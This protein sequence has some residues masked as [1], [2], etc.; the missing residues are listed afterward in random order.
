MVINFIEIILSL[1]FAEGKNNFFEKISTYEYQSYINILSSIIIFL[2]GF[3]FE[4]LSLSEIFIII[5]N[6]IKNYYQKISEK[7]VN[8]N[9]LNNFNDIL[10]NIINILI[11]VILSNDNDINDLSIFDLYQFFEKMK[12]IKMKIEKIN[13]KRNIDINNVDILNSLDILLLIYELA[14][15]KNNNSELFK[16]FLINVI[17]NLNDEINFIK[18]EDYDGLIKNINALKNILE[19]K[20]LIN[21]SE[22]EYF[23][24]INKIYRIYYNRIQDEN[25]RFLMVKFSFEN[26]KLNYNSIYFLNTIFDIKFN[27]DS[28]DI[29]EF[30][31]SEK[32][33]RYLLFLNQINSEIFNQILLYYFEILFHQ[34]ICIKNLKDEY[35][36]NYIHFSQTIE[37][38]INYMNND[39]NSNLS[40]LKLVYAIAYIKVFI[41]YFSKEYI[42][43]KEELLVDDLNK[44]T[45]LINSQ[46]EKNK[47]IKYTL[48]IYFFKCIYYNNKDLDNINKL[49]TYITTKNNFPFKEDYIS[50]HKKIKKEIFIF[51]NCLIPM[52]NIDIYMQEKTKLKEVDKNLINF[53]FYNTKAFDIFYCLFINQIFSPI[54]NEDINQRE[55]ANLFL[56]NFIK[57]FEQNIINENPNMINKKIIEVFKNLYN[58]KIM[59]KYKIISC[60]QLEILFYAF[61]FVLSISDINDDNNI[62]NFYSL[63]LTSN[64]S[65]IISSSYVPGTTPFNNVYLNSYYALKELMPITNENEYGFYICSCGQYYTLGKCTC[66]AY[67]FNCQNCGLIIGGIGHYLEERE[68]HFRLYLNKDKF[69]ENVFAREEV[70]SNKIPYMFF[71]EYK[72]KYIDKYLEK[73]PKGINKEDISF[74]I[75]RKNFNIRKMSELTFRIMNFILYSHLLCANVIGNLSDDILFNNYTH[76]N[77]NCFQCIEKDWEIIND[78]LKEKGINNIRAFLNI[79]FDDII[80]ILKKAEN[81]DSIDK[82]KIVEEN[83]N[84]YINDLTNDK[85]KLKVKLDEYKKYNEKIKNS[86]PNY[87]DEIIAENYPPIED[88]YPKNKYPFLNYFMKSE[89][90]DINILYNELR[91]I[92]NYQQ[93]YPLINQVIINS[94]EFRLLYNLSNINKLSN[95][96]LKKY[97]YKISR[98]ESQ[99]ISLYFSE[100]NEKEYLI[101]FIKSWNEIKKYC[102]RYLCRPD[103]PILDINK[104]MTLNYFLVDDGQLGGGMYLA[105]AYSN[106]IEWQNKFISLILDN[107][108]QDSVLYCYVEQL[109]EEIYVQDAKDENI[110]KLDENIQEKLNDMIKV[111]SIRNIFDNNGDINY[112]NYK[113]I[114]FNFD[115]IESEL[116]KLILPGLKKFKSSEDPIKFMVYLYE[117]NRSQNSQILLK[118][119][120]KYPSKELNISEKK[121]IYNFLNKYKNNRK[122]VNE[123]LF[124]CQ[125][126]IDYIHKENFNTLTSIANIIGEIPS[127]IELNKEL[128]HFFN[129]NKNLCV[130]KLLN[131]YKYFEFFCWK[132]IKLNINEQ[133][134]EK[135]EKNKKNEI[136]NFF[137]EYE[138]KEKNKLIKKKDLVFALRRF[139]SRYL[140]GKRG[141]TDIDEKQKLI[142]QIIR[143]DLWEN[144]IIQNEDIFQKE[145]YSLTFDLQ[146]SQALDFYEILDGDSYDIFDIKEI[147]E[148]SN[149][150]IIVEDDDE[151][152]KK[153]KVQVE[154]IINSFIFS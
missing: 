58:K 111:Y 114:K 15:K 82:R 97:S 91:L 104:Q 67:Q 52:K 9:N 137:K 115:E 124:S 116:G 143:Y 148:D 103:M 136:I 146:V 87:I 98:D 147:N 94:E 59:D 78:I 85:N 45:H 51:E 42:N 152:Q 36:Y 44:F 12:Y 27:A 62:S 16:K 140:A 149:S 133:Y 24:A 23:Y 49:N 118:Y 138:E 29:F 46:D 7:I 11:E 28:K 70:I 8:R 151:N 113:R 54:F 125:M 106:F 6:Y 72:K 10:C 99:K 107:I 32:N 41:H 71:D 38:I 144:Y 47:G 81:M 109:N 21:N 105:S 17:K 3:S 5:Y 31:E 30:F 80:V 22:N 63:L 37:Y 55:E 130:N 153:N 89:Y 92:R 19:N 132:E 33:N 101:P 79:I 68:D 141:D 26:N 117:G 93:K 18:N 43:E 73:E 34:H 102:T 13:K 77:Y 64:T 121:A 126:L 65:E 145:I 127:Y 4:I 83:V 53:E 134:E 88:Y 74:F 90:P 69:N 48:E 129:E 122:I 131:V 135:I 50:Y 84:K 14:T 20:F 76:G 95:K 35:K 1:K 110:L 25:F 150:N 119:E 40:N 112:S 139:I 66:P 128:K 75:E 57:E 108:N 142:G 60:N 123:F 2:E 56:N 96:L 100:K 120:N 86:E 154:N 39:F 61:R